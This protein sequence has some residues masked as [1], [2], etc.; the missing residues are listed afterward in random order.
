LSACEILLAQRMINVTI[1]TTFLREHGLTLQYICNYFWNVHG[2]FVLLFLAIFF[3][4]DNE[5]VFDSFKLFLF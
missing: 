1:H 2:K 4:R 3:I 5:H